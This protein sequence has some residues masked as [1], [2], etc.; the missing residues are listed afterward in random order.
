MKDTERQPVV[1][2]VTKVAE[3]I[4]NCGREE[5]ID[6]LLKLR[7]K[8]EQVLILLRGLMG[9]WDWLEL[10]LIGQVKIEETYYFKNQN[11]IQ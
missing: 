5:S 10:R 7:L 1:G 8:G 2:G 4:K 9:G 11:T 6:A 3:L